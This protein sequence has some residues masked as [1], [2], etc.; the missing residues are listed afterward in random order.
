MCIRDRPVGTSCRPAV[1]FCDAAEVCDGTSGACPA[2]LKQPS[3]LLC[4]DVAPGSNCDV[5]EF[6]TGNTD[7]CPADGFQVGGTPCRA[8]TGMCDPA[9]AC[10]GT[11]AF[12][13]VDAKVP[14]DN[15]NCTGPGMPNAC[16]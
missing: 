7:A 14:F 2:D 15:S 4:R 11:D 5:Q 12:C 16:C 8:S 1:D 13:P 9:E 3:S 6:C 10:T